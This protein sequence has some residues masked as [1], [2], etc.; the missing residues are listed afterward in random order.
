MLGHKCRGANVEAQLR[1]ANVGAHM[2]GCKSRVRKCQVRKCEGAKVP[3]PEN[4][5][6]YINFLIKIFKIR[7]RIV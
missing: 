7:F 1:S 3:H 2:S 4:Q 6:A 5:A